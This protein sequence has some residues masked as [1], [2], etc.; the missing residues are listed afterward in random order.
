MKPLAYKLI[1]LLLAFWA[2]GLQ[3]AQPSLQEGTRLLLAQGYSLDEAVSQARRRYPGKVLSA[4]TIRQ[5]D[6]PV[7]RIRIIDDGRVRG[8]RY[9]GDTG[10][11]LG[12]RGKPPPQGDQRSR[13]RR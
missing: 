6:H 4:E 10:R 5:G 1:P 3:A 9:D 8:L 11:P 7:H 12:P 2:G 13:Y